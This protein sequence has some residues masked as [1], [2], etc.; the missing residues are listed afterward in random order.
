[1]EAS[2]PRKLVE[3]LVK[4]L[5]LRDDVNDTHVNDVLRHLRRATVSSDDHSVAIKYR[6]KQ[7]ILR[8]NDAAE[9]INKVASF[10]KEYERLMKMNSSLL[11][12][13]V[14]MLEQLAYPKPLIG[15]AKLHQDI[16]QTPAVKQE[17]SNEE[18]HAVDVLLT[19]SLPLPLTTNNS[20]INSE[21]NSLIWCSKELESLL[22]RDL[23]Y[24]F[25]GIDG[26][27]IKYDSR[28]ELYVVDPALGLKQAVKDTV[29]CL[30]ELG[31]LFKIV[32]S[33]IHK[34]NGGNNVITKDAVNKGQVVQAFAFSLNEELHD[35]YR[36]LA[37]LDVELNDLT[38]SNH[39]NDD[40]AGSHGITLVRLRAWIQEPLDR[41]LLMARLV[42]AV[43]PLTG[44]ALTSRLHGH[45]KHG[46]VVISE[47]STR[48]L[49]SVCAPIY[50]MMVRW[51]LY[52]EL[53]DP[54]DEFFV[55]AKT[56][57]V[58]SMWQDTYFLR[59]QTLPS[60][61]PKSLAMKVLIIGKSI[62]FIRAC[63]P[64]LPTVK[65]VSTKKKGM[66]RPSVADA[67]GFGKVAVV[68]Y[69]EIVASER[70]QAMPI[71]KLEDENG[72]SISG[73]T[74]DMV[75]VLQA[76]S[77]GDEEK[78]SDIVNK[79]ANYTDTKL[80]YMMNSSFNL[81]VHLLALKKF[82]LLGQGDFVTCLMDSVGP[83]LKKRANQLYRHNLT[84]MLE[85]ALRSSNAQFESTSV[86]D[87]I[88]V[89]LLDAQSGDT[90]WEV[91]ALDYAVDSPLNAVVHTD[92]ISKYR[93]A[94]SM[95]WKLKRVEWTLSGAWKQLMTL[96]H[97]K[98]ID[99]SR[100]PKLKPIIH[101]C[102]L[103]RGQMVHV[104]NNLCNFLMFEVMESAW[105]TL[106]EKLAKALSL[107][108]VIKAH[109]NYLAEIL[110]RALLGPQHEGLC[111][112]LNQLLQSILRFCSL[113]ETLVADVLTAVSQAQS[114]VRQDD[115]TTYNGVPGYLVTRLDENIKDYHLQFDLFMTMLRDGL[116][117]EKVGTA[118]RDIV[119]FL[120]FRLD[121]NEFH[122]NKNKHLPQ[123]P[124]V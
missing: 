36:L 6:I 72:V 95:L 52:G 119:R 94:F 56:G 101:K 71:G 13:S 15:N 70:I 74:K 57:V 53:Y 114:A 21:V 110:D 97:S 46:D 38:S 87:R 79:I 22:I 103:H 29:L 34:A 82:M 49:T 84:G 112:Q 78:L 31:F 54:Y 47:L 23:I 45:T 58:L 18:K 90:G 44:G 77:Y 48:L 102:T 104:V 50:A 32:S 63:I 61:L 33:Y 91:F 24:V 64:K 68:S 92:A 108:E 107:D 4:L 51:I 28:S 60:F 106:Q 40:S 124:G 67:L 98:G 111:V 116:A 30:C 109:D 8:H 62:N 3:S 96:T 88:G 20:A 118:A 42:D 35:Y 11:Y 121:F 37:V 19:S 5:L 69:D 43:G 117:T 12:A 81:N 65:S 66:E 99:S 10:E 93:L 17:N 115:S 59:T 85:V 122:A 25:Q 100:F 123:F 76:T 39:A 113:E 120:S 14:A 86:L 7:A 9:G 80:L 75:D 89:R 16:L 1:M 105:S 73:A 26:K 2:H 41:M 55:G 83:E 27:Y